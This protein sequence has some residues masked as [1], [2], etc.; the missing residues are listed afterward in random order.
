[1]KD[2]I[3]VNGLK[4]RL[5]DIAVGRIAP[6]DSMLGRQESVLKVIAENTANLEELKRIA[7]AAELQAKTA[8]DVAE[9]AKKDAK[10]S[11]T[12]SIAS[13]VISIGTLAFDV[14]VRLF[15]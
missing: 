13:I 1:M 2:Y 9:A 10:F 11:K 14:V 8:H 7:A 5:P 15:L 4:I 3:D 12:V 6:E